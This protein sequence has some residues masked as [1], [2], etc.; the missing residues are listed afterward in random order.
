MAKHPWL[1]NRDG[2]YYLRARVPADLVDSIGRR[3]IKRSL[4][5][6]DAKEASRR[7]RTEAAEVERLFERAR[8]GLEEEPCPG[9]PTESKIRRLVHDWFCR[10]ERA[11]GMRRWSRR[12][13]TLGV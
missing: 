7:L 3:E 4:G 11:E 10:R 2:R 5:T 8:L 9:S 1:L 12:H 6:S 13:V